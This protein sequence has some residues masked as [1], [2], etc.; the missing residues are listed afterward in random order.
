MST[1]TSIGAALFTDLSV[2]TGISVY[3]GFGPSAEAVATMPSTLDSNATTGFP[4]LFK[5]SSTTVIPY[6]KIKNVRE[7]PAVGTPANIVNVPVF[8]QKIGQSIGGQADAPTL[9]LT[10]NYI[11]SDWDAVPS[12]NTQ[13]A[14]ITSLVATAAQTLPATNSAILVGMYVSGVGVVVGTTVLAISGTS[15]TLSAAPSAGSNITLSFSSLY[16][17]DTL[18]NMVGDGITR[19]WRFTLMNSDVTS[20]APIAPALAKYDSLAGGLG[21][22]G[23]AQYYFKGRMESLLV[24]PSLTDATTAKISI[25]LQSPFYGAYSI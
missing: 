9:E 12:T 24:T 18:G 13:I 20:A 23:N 6:A 19:V 2:Y 10:I 17:E 22:T 16:A 4:F 11:G 1:L 15:L 7:F 5:A 21:T 25:S 14:V 8:G 3:N